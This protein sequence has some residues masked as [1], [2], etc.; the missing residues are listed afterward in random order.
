MADR[1][2]FKRWFC[3]SGQNHHHAPI[4]RLSKLP[5][6]CGTAHHERWLCIEAA[7]MC[8]A[9][10]AEESRSSALLRTSGSTLTAPYLDTSEVTERKCGIR[11][12]SP[13]APMSLRNSVSYHHQRHRAWRGS[14]RRCGCLPSP[15]D[16][17]GSSRSR[18]PAR[19]QG[20]PSPRIHPCRSGRRIEVPRVRRGR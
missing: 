16:S 1:C 6:R 10:S 13:S 19:G 3:D 18:S 14:G 8:S 9:Q 2:A 20:Q 15:R 17:S 4:Y 5:T 11:C 7:F 12:S